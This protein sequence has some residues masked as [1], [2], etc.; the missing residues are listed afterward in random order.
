M[1][2]LLTFRG[3]PTR[4]YY[5]EGPVPEDPQVLWS[6]PGES[7]G[8]CAES[9]ASGQPKVWCGTGWTGQPAV[10]ERDGRTW[11]VFGAYD[12]KAGMCGSVG[13][14]VRH[15][16]LNHRPEL[17]AGVEAAG[18]EV[19]IGFVLGLVL[20]DIRIG[21][22]FRGVD[23]VDRRHLHAEDLAGHAFRR[24]V[25]FQVLGAD[26]DGRRVVIFVGKID[27]LQAFLGDRHRTHDH[28]DAPGGQRRD[29]AVPRRWRHDAFKARF[30]AER[31]HDV[32]FPAGPIA[33]GIGNRE[34]RIGLGGYAD[35]DGLL[36]RCRAAD[37]NHRKG[38]QYGLEGMFHV[39][40][41]LLLHSQFLPRPDVL[42]AVSC[43]VTVPN[44]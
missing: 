5:G 9:S 23:L 34:G 39:H 20:A 42:P 21:E 3:S 29:N 38:Q 10:F 12:P 35:A 37:G 28:V 25:E 8:M 6:Y 2:G 24:G 17:V 36:R 40:S 26:D 43:P 27:R 14:L 44:R 30:I 15:P 7:G 32:D 18:D 4:N 1:P 41:P 11:V 16:R 33:R 31:V 22:V 13:D 19:L